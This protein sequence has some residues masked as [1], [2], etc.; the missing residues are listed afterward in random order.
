MAGIQVTVIEAAQQI[1]GGLRSSELTLPGL[2]HDDCSAVH[3]MAAASPFLNSLNLEQHGLIWRHAEVAAAHPLDNGHAGVLWRSVSDT[4]TGL[5]ADGAAWARLFGPLSARFDSLA[6]DLFRP[7]VHV[8]RHPVMLAGFG[9]SAVAPAS[10]LARRWASEEAQALFGGVAAH[11]MYPLTRPLSSAIGLTLIAAGHAVGWPV[12]EG[13]SQSIARALEALLLQHG[14]RIE[15]GRMLESLDELRD[16]DIILLDLEPA[17]VARVAGNR[18]PARFRRAYGRFRRA[19]AAYK[20]DL[21]VEG[22]IPW[23]N[24][25]ARLAG[26][27]HLGGAFGEVRAT[28]DQVHRGRMPERPFVLVAQQYLADPTRSRGNVHPVYAYAHVPFGFSGN[29]SAAIVAQLERFAPGVTER[30]VAT[31]SRSPRELEE[32]NPNLVGGDIVTGQNDPL[33]LLMR[34]VIGPHPYYTGIPGVY[35]CSAATPP[36]AGTHG[37]G[38]HNAALAALA[39]VR[40]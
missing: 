33:Q 16:A 20:L 2:L 3:T 36:G 34:P 26:T 13:G 35:I 32:H 11:A 31:H 15:T 23:T 22:G 29:A 25:H 5:G 27:V 14:G 24:E 4:A 9:L 8:P 12:A 10:I 7:I 39:H 19:P 6:T 21:A 37:M 28:E 18:L 17:A 40:S 1:G 30:I 38:G